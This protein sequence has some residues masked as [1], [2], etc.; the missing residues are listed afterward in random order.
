MMGTTDGAAARGNSCH[1]GS[2]PPAGP[3]VD[4]S[5]HL[6]ED[7]GEGSE[8]TRAVGW[9]LGGQSCRWQEPA[10]KPERKKVE[11]PAR[12]SPLNSARS[13]RPRSLETPKAPPSPGGEGGAR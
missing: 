12:R 7:G 2:E 4:A 1:R 6:L 9:R 10:R 11:P 8:T 5:D 3:A 13:R